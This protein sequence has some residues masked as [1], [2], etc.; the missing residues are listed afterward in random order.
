MRDELC[1][2]LHHHK[3]FEKPRQHRRCRQVTAAIT[4]T[5][6]IPPSQCQK[7][8]AWHTWTAEVGDTCG[9]A[10]TGKLGVRLRDKERPPHATCTHIWKAQPPFVGAIWGS[11]SSPSQVKSNRDVHH[12]PIPSLLPPSLLP[13]IILLILFRRGTRP[14][15]RR[16]P[17]RDEE[18][19]P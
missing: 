19:G 1:L 18:R 8:R 12:S 13:D 14:S 17:A 3:A 15:C 5:D 9:A 11:S 7:T 6:V 2:I 10:A 4:G 16:R